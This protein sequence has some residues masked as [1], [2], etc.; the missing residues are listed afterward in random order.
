MLLKKTLQCD[1][2]DSNDYVGVDEV[3]VIANII[4]FSAAI[5]GGYINAEGKNNNCHVDCG[6]RDSRC[7]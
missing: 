6:S 1:D 5:G 3:S 7:N 4:F 2:F